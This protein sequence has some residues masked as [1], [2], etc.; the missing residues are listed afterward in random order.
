MSTREAGMS[1]VAD[2][3]HEATVLDSLHTELASNEAALQFLVKTSPA[4][5]L[6]PGIDHRERAQL[7]CEGESQY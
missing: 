6:S 4:G 5:T 1:S 7:Q 3:R 2:S